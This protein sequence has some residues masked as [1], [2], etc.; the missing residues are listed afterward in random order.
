MSYSYS[1][2]VGF[3]NQ[4]TTNSQTIAIT[5]AAGTVGDIRLM[6]V[7]G[8]AANDTMDWTTPSGWTALGAVQRTF[9]SGVASN[10][11]GA[12][13]LFWRAGDGASETIQVTRVG[14]VNHKAIGVRFVSDSNE[15]PRILA[16][17]LDD[18][19]GSTTA[20]SYQP[21]T[22][23]MPRTAT[24]A[25]FAFIHPDLSGTLTVVT[26]NGFTSLF[27]TG[28]TPA[29]VFSYQNAAASGA[30][31]M[32]TY[33]AGSSDRPWSSKTIALAAVRGGIY[34]DGAVHLS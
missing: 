12:M 25:C 17:P 1:S 28:G 2:G 19:T 29:G 3:S 24:L 30:T 21:P 18:S 7:Q 4:A 26:A 23:T 31:S 33:R 6:C 20:T 11:Y 22:F 14:G 13:Q 5:F 15:T 16:G 10:R 34:V 9:Y 32:P 8:R 27:A